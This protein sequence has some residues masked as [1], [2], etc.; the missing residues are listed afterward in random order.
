VKLGGMSE[1]L[2]CVPMEGSRVSCIGEG[3]TQWLVLGLGE[4]V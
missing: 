1:K 2:V 4:R 3:V